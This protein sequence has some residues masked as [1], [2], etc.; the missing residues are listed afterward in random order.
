MAKDLPQLRD[1]GAGELLT[2]LENHELGLLGVTSLAVQVEAIGMRWWHLPIRDMDTPDAGF[3][4]RWREI[5]RE[6][7]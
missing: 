6:L 2:L 4:T 3:E 7:R 1:G 5:G